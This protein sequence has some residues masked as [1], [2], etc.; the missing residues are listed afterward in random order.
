VA[1]A[2]YEWSCQIC[3]KVNAAGSPR[4]VVCE[5]P[6][7]IS[8]EEIEGRQRARSLGEA[9][10]ASRHDLA[11]PPDSRGLRLLRWWGRGVAWLGLVGCS[12]GF[13]IMAFATLASE[14]GRWVSVPAALLCLY[15]GRVYWKELRSSRVPAA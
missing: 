8:S 15:F 1:A 9:Y 12:T 7:I 6:D 10:V 11:L 4:C 2:N 13:V 3:E 5:A 14:K